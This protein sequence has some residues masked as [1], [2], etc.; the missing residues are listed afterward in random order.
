MLDI[1]LIVA[2]VF[3]LIA[4]GYA[5]VRTGYFS[6]TM[7]DALNGFSIKIATP[8]L[9]FSAMVRIDFDTAFSINSLTSFYVGAL[10]CFVIGIALARIV[11]GRRPGEAVAVGF[12]ATF[13]NSLLLGIPIVERA[14]GEEALMITF[15]IVAFHAPLLYTVGMVTMELMRR[16][17]K[18]LPQTL[19]TALRAIIRN[20]LIAGIAAGIILNLSGLTLPDPVAL[21]INML[22]ASAIPVAL[23]GMGAALT[24]Y[25]ITADLPEIAMVSALSL[26]IHPLIA[27]TLAHVVFDLPTSAVLGIVTVAAMPPGVNIYIFA[28]LYNRAVGLAASSLLIATSLGV[29]SVTLWLYALSLALG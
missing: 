2:P 16:D 5:A 17:G 25:K 26:V 4:I 1:F 23:V 8:A 7:T 19:L 27:F 15:G 9:L 12:S 6:D 28:S 3:V 22:A 29:V 21:P 13:S 20:P 24:R 10:A 11:F 18:S 14:H